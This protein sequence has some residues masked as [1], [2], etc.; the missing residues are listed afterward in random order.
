MYTCKEVRSGKLF[1]RVDEDHF[2]I[3]KYSSYAADA[4][5][6]YDFGIVGITPAFLDDLYAKTKQGVYRK[7]EYSGEKSFDEIVPGLWAQ[8]CA[9]SEAGIL[10]RAYTTDYELSAPAKYT[11][12]GQNY[13]VL[14]VA[15]K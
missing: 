15:V 9:D 7:Y 12:S 8:V 1:F 3:A 10:Q 14:F 6:D 11:D 4:K 2:P 13:T 5:G